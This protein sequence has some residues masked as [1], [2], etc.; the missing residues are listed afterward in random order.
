VLKLVTGKAFDSTLAI[1]TNNRRDDRDKV[2]SI[3]QEKAKV[4][5]THEYKSEDETAANVE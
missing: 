5:G 4:S 3:C 2:S 1:T